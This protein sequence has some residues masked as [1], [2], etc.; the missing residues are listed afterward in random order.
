MRGVR[1]REPLTGF[2]PGLS[3]EFCFHPLGVP[4]HGFKS[5]SEVAGFIMVLAEEEA[6]SRGRKGWK[7]A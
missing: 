7:Q 4:P 6:R 1:G 2:W 5:Q 3:P